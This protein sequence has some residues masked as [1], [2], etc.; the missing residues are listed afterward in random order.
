MLNRKENEMEET[1][2]LLL[3]CSV[4]AGAMFAL[5]FFFK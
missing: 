2:E 3:V 5:W 1:M 4:I